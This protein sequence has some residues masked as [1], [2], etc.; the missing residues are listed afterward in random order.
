MILASLTCRSMI[1]TWLTCS[2][3]DSD[4]VNLLAIRHKSVVLKWLLLLRSPFGSRSSPEAR[5]K[6]PVMLFRCFVSWSCIIQ[7]IPPCSWLR[8]SRHIFAVGYCKRASLT[9]ARWATLHWS[10]QVQS[11]FGTA[12]CTF[13]VLVM[14]LLLWIMWSTCACLYILFR[15]NCRVSTVGNQINLMI[16]SSV[17]DVLFSSLKDILELS[18]SFY[19]LSHI[20]KQFKSVHF[21]D[22]LYLKLQ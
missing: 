14:T 3:Y 8:A 16:A 9:M 4:I 21:L 1:L 17:S 11:T 12:G 7:E 20:R 15:R 10:H 22:K 13:A 2:S 18:S 6:H 19:K 5:A